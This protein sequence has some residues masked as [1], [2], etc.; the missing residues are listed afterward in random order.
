MGHRLEK[1]YTYEAAHTQENTQISKD[2]S[3]IGHAYGTQ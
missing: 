1:E 3:S 2:V